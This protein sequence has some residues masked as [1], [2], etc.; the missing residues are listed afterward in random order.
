[1]RFLLCGGSMKTLS[2]LADDYLA[3]AQRLKKKIDELEAAADTD[4]PAAVNHTIAVYYDM[5]HD[6]MY[7]YHQLKKY[8]KNDSS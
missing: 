7:A 2:E 5:L 6:T 1:M 8:T 4:N 3:E